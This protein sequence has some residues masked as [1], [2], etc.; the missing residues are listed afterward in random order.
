MILA[1]TK[2]IDFDISI[3]STLSRISGLRVTRTA[4]TQRRQNIGCK[5]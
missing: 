4:T 3:I 5:K 1:E 2:L